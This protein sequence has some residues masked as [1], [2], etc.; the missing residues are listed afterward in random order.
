VTKKVGD[1]MK[2]ETLMASVLRRI[3]KGASCWIWTGAKLANGY[4]KAPRPHGSAGHVKYVTAHRLVYE[5]LVGPLSAELHL[6]HLCGNRM[7]VNP[8]HLRPVTAAEH[9]EITYKPRRL[10]RLVAAY[11]RVMGRYAARL[12]GA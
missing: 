8:D 1:W 2:P 10:A 6:H 5:L 7:C 12:E 3:D 4:G 11:E 9:A